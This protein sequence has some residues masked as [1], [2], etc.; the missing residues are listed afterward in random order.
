MF[1]TDPLGISTKNGWQFCSI[2]IFRNIPIRTSSHVRSEEPNV[3][4]T[5][6]I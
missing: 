1:Q 4:E 3:T 6:T 5:Y 2:F